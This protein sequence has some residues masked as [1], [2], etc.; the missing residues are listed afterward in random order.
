MR[1]P[2]FITP[3]FITLARLLL[4]PVGVYTLFKNGGN[5]PTW[6]Y[7]SWIVFFLL[8]LSDIADGN[9]ARS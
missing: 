9:L 3:N 5:D 2:G 1:L 7:I 6:Q 4:V 8:G